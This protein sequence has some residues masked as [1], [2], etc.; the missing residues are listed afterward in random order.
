MTKTELYNKFRQ[1]QYKADTEALR[2]KIWALQADNEQDRAEYERIA[3]R[4]EN[5]SMGIFKASHNILNNFS[6]QLNDET[7]E[8]MYVYLNTKEKY[9]KLCEEVA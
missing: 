9:Q 1:E 7:V 8:A 3:E 5:Q 6:G 4:D 2:W